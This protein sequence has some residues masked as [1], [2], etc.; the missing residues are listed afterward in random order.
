M[1]NAQSQL[2]QGWNRSNP[3]ELV[4]QNNGCELLCPHS[5]A[6]APLWGK[7]QGL[8]AGPSSEIYG[9]G[10]SCLSHADREHRA[11][12]PNTHQP[13]TLPLSKPVRLFHINRVPKSLSVSPTQCILQV[14]KGK[15][16]MLCLLTWPIK[17]R[18]GAKGRSYW[19]S[20]ARNTAI[21]G[22]FQ[23]EQGFGFY[24]EPR[25]HITEAPRRKRVSGIK[26][27]LV[28]DTV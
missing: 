1:I 24:A 15:K 7:L 26:Q 27:A 3:L 19:D 23:T 9:T 18:Q 17:P 8:L 25:Q 20:N 10:R 28:L 5:L 4:F 6:R 2:M 12:S 14:F 13:Q 11:M 21:R 16:Q 22:R